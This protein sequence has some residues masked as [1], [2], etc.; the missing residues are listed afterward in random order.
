M[1]GEEMTDLI[2]KLGEEE[3]KRRYYNEE[4]KELNKQIKELII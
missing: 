4:I 2:D 1:T 3:F